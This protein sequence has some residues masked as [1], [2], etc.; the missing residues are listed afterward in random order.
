[1]SFLGLHI[2]SLEYENINNKYVKINVGG[3]LF[4]T[5]VSTLNKLDYFN[6]IFTYRRN[7]C[8][9]QDEDGNPS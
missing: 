8:H 2:K 3:K 9:I 7:D 6:A 4:A 5:H 1:M